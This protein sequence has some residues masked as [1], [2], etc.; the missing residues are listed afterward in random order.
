MQKW[1]HGNSLWSPELIEKVSQKDFKVRPMDKKDHYVKRAVAIAGD[2]LQIINGDIYIDG[3][4]SEQPENVQY[5][6][7]VF[8]NLNSINPKRMRDMGIDQ[9]DFTTGGAVLNQKQVEFI[10]E[11]NSQIQMQRR[12]YPA[13]SSSLFPFDANIN[14]NW[15]V[16]NY[17]PIWIPEKGAT[18]DLSLDNLPL[19]KRII[20]E[21]EDNDLEVRDGIIIINGTETNSYTFQQD[22]YWAMGDNRHNS[23]DSR[24]WGFVP[25]DHM[26]GKPLIIWFSSKNGIRWNRIFKLAGNI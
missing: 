12:I 26:V 11:A 24:S 1:N 6:Y 23:E 18:V 5:V 13:N 16:D 19:Y 17:G 22:Y 2:T 20:S 7:N 25:F 9:D 3:N 14:N 21:Y 15:S 10:K 4:P 8:G